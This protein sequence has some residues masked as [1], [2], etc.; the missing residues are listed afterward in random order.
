[1]IPFFSPSVSTRRFALSHRYSL[2]LLLLEVP[3]SLLEAKVALLVGAAGAKAKADESWP[4]AAAE[5]EHGKDDAEAEAD[6]GFDEQVR[7]A[8]VPLFVEKGFA[9]GAR[10][11]ARGRRRGGRRC[12][13]GHW[14]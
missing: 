3:R 5:D 12:G 6:G 1:M 4:R 11:G 14:D 2:C 7:E 8:A 9:D 10:D 13:L